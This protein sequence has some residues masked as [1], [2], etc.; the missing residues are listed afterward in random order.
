MQPVMPAP[1][2]DVNAIRSEPGLG[3]VPGLVWAFKFHPD[4]AAEALAVDRPIE[5]PLDGWLWLHFNLADS[6][7]GRWLQSAS[8]AA[9]ALALLLSR[10]QRQQLHV[11]D[12]CVYGVLADL[13]RRVDGPSDEIAHLYFLMT[14]RVLI[15]GRHHTLVS[16]DSAKASI[17][18]GGRRLSRVAALLE[19]IVEQVL[20][21]MESLTDSLGGEL[22]QI[23]DQIADNVTSDHRR[24]L[25]RVRRTAV[26]LHRQLSGLRALFHRLERGGIADL[27]PAM[28][29]AVG[30][31]AQHLDALDHVIVEIRDRARLLQEDVTLAVAEE[32]NRHVK[33]LTI[34][35]ILFLPPTLVTGIYGMNVKGLPVADSEEGFLW[36]SAMMLASAAAVY[37]MMRAVGIFK[38]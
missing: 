33:I 28:Q 2:C 10:D 37:L 7:S 30:T 16:V 8:L 13:V 5:A 4:G 1:D 21:G 6:Q 12:D 3:L 26:R 17:E 9:P 31:L 35:T 20:D 34:L 14:D 24:Q 11:A 25:G 29:L 19:L 15:S 36:V 27:K 23:E 32:T 18:R 22:D 38:K